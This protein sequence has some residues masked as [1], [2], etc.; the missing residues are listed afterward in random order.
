MTDRRLVASG[1]LVAERYELQDLVTEG[2]GCLRWRA[3]DTVLNRNVGVEMLPSDD[4]RAHMWVEAARSSTVVTDP[5]FLR[6]MD[7]LHDEYGHQI[8]VREWARAFSL[9]QILAESPLPNRRAATVIA[10][11]AEAI[12]HA[13]EAGIY[14]RRLSPHQVLLKQSGA[15]RI[16]GLGVA[17]ALDP[18]GVGDSNGE[19]DS[20]ELR[21][22]LDIGKLLYASLTSRWPDGY[23]DGLP[24]A[25]AEHGRL[26]RPR[27]VKAGISRDVDRVCD[28][29][30]G[31]PPR[32]HQDP[33]RGAI[34][35]AQELRFAGVDERGADEASLSEVSSPDLLRLD[36]VIEPSGPPPGLTPPRRRPKAFAPPPPSTL[37]RGKATAV[38]ATSGH[39]LPVALALLVGLVLLS[40]LAFFVLRIQGADDDAVDSDS[41]VRSLPITGLYDLDPFGDGKENRDKVKF[42]GDGDTSTAW[43]T[44]EYYG[45]PKLGGLKPGVGLVVDLGGRRDISSVRV[46]SSGGPIDFELYSQGSTSA[47]RPRSIKG[48]DKIASVSD[49]GDDSSVTISEGTAARYFVVWVTKLPEVRPDTYQGAITDISVR[50]SAD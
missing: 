34:D 11:V 27:Q 43:T 15:V 50:G 3:R 17:A 1:D 14:H 10:E 36:P 18:R 4:P 41:A 2:H 29:I 13:H 24:A 19:P 28:R 8:I 9:D 44:V 33:L 21:D 22:V 23:T 45:S 46:R 47:E 39:R 16:V 30:L 20:A 35:I 31:D 7:L 6:V 26:L 5:R 32:H 38:K 48:L 37:E 49:A 12:A 42:A 25:P 40:V